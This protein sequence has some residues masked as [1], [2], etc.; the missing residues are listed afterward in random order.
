MKSCPNCFTTKNFQQNVCV[1][2]GFKNV[3]ARETRALPL[4]KVLNQRY[5]VGR[6]L[7]IGGFG[8][9]YVAY[10]M[11]KKERVAIKEY[12]PAEWATRLATNSKVI[13]SS[14][15]NGNFYQHGRK[16]FIN[17]ARVLSRLKDV[18]N[19]ANV[20]A[21]FEENGTAYMVM[22]LLEGYT[23]NEYIQTT[24]KRCISYKEANQ[25]VQSV[26]MALQ[27]IHG[28]QLLH[29]DISPD[30]IIITKDKQVH[31]IDFGATRMYALNSPQSMSVLVK[32]GFA[33]I[34]QYSRAG[35]Q[36]P[37]TDIY[38][39]AATYYYLV[40]GKKPPDAPDRIMGVPM[41]PL[42]NLIPD[43]PD[44]ISDAVEHAMEENWR[45]RPQ[46]V[47]DFIME[48]GMSKK[49][50]DLPPTIWHWITSSGNET[51]TSG[52]KLEKACVLMQVGNKRQRYY[53]AQK[54]TL[55]IG[56]KV[57]TELRCVQISGDNQVSRLHCRIWYDSKS[58][59][60]A[61]LNYSGNRTFTSQGI[62]E[63]NQTAYLMKGE[64]IY[65]QT[66][67]ERYI[68]YLEVE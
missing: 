68:F 50:Q 67:Q 37:W 45:T 24:D 18:P 40:T 11:Q 19:V 12:F 7:G 28:Y 49:Q 63:K 3:A 55:D 43:I 62:L 27:Q 53:F 21:L 57:G 39:L 16:V 34:E 8:I 36:G 46:S 44:C 52:K 33:P 58:G 41:I 31:L 64:W 59:R 25:I 2:C 26:G 22:E 65:I 32:S 29:R 61:V 1:V 20:Y 14:R 51:E 9:T 4:E 56:K 15:T 42:R 48:M 60:F 5:V 6:V 17:E 30:N 66:K 10:D 47:R 54:G 23:L 35:N 13:P 38:A